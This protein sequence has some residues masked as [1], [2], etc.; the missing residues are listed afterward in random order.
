MKKNEYQAEITNRFGE[1]EGIATI[2]KS[3]TQSKWAKRRE[4]NRKEYGSPTAQMG[5]LLLVLPPAMSLFFCSFASVVQITAESPPFPLAAEVYI[6]AAAT[7]GFTL[8]FAFTLI[9]IE[10]NTRAK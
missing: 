8:G 2:R 4:E 1:P 6:A 3:D 5:I 9:A 7:S 10:Q